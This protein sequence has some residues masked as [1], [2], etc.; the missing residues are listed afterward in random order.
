MHVKNFVAAIKVNG[1]VLRE[2]SGNTVKLPFDSEYSI[3][4]KN[5]STTQK[6]VVDITIDGNKVSDSGIV[7]NPASEV[8][9]ERPASDSA[10]GNKFKFIAKTEKVEEFRGNK[11]GDGLVNINVRFEAQHQ[12]NPLVW[13]PRPTWPYDS[14][15]RY[16]LEHG[17]PTKLGN[18]IDYGTSK[19]D[20]GLH[21]AQNAVQGSYNV[22]Y[23][24]ASISSD[25]VTTTRTRSA[26]I[27]VP[28]S[29]SHQTFTKTYVST[30]E[31]TEY[32]IQFS[33]VGQEDS[34]AVPQPVAV[35]TKITCPTCGTVN[36]A[37][38]KFCPECGTAVKIY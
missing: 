36:K 27:T 22:T 12:Y 33:L 31:T 2:F 7:V 23:A 15:V 32:N 9:L 25:G 30:L 26:G 24:S 20:S 37:T 11:A 35:N 17:A 38:N 3:L 6:A 29:E 8:E 13:N 28:G 19:L 16:W 21:A 5:L 4:L 10:V 1:K 18:L 34:T 14:P